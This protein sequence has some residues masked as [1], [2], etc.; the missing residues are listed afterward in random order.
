MIAADTVS[1][2][3][4]KYFGQW[5]VL[6]TPFRRISELHDTELDDLV[7]H[8]YYNL[9]CA[10]KR[11]PEYWRDPERIKKDMLLEA[12]GDEYITNILSMIQAKTQ[13]IED[14]ISG[15]IRKDMEPPEKPSILANRYSDLNV[16]LRVH[17]PWCGNPAEPQKQQGPADEELEW[18]QKQRQL[19]DN[20]DLRVDQA[21]L[22]HRGDPIEAEK[23]R[24]RAQE[25]GKA[26]A[27]LGGPGTGKTTVASASIHRAKTLGARILIA[28]PTGQMSSRMREIFPELEVDTCH[29]IF[30]FH[31][32]EMEAASLMSEYDLVVV[33]EVSQLSMEQFERIMRLWMMADRVPALIFLGDFYQLPGVDPTRAIDSMAWK[34][35]VYKI[36][37]VKPWRCKCKTLM[38]KIQATRTAKP[39]QKN[40]MSIKRGHEAWSG[41]LGPSPADIRRIL[42]TTNKKTTFVTC[43]RRAANKINKLVVNEL[44]HRP[45]V[46]LLGEVP[47]HYDIEPDNYDDHG[48]LKADIPP[49]PATISLYKGMRLFLTHNMDKKNDFVN[50]MEVMVDAFRETTARGRKGKSIRVL[51]KTGKY[52][53]V[54]LY[55]ESPIE[56]DKDK[57][58][59][60]YPIRIGYAT[61]L[62][63]VQ[64][65]TL[66]HATIWLDITGMKAAGHVALSRVQHDTDYLPTPQLSFLLRDRTIYI[67]IYSVALLPFFDMNATFGFRACVCKAYAPNNAFNAMWSSVGML[68]MGIKWRASCMDAIV[69]VSSNVELGNAP[70]RMLAHMTYQLKHVGSFR[71]VPSNCSRV[72][73]RVIIETSRSASLTCMYIHAER[74]RCDDNALLRINGDITPEHFVPAM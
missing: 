36:T 34:R 53:E 3:N 74:T 7:P 60:F 21:L 48:K 9:A 14:Y 10:L 67:Y 4:D 26:V 49:K 13:L 41:E 17:W 1:R 71:T 39:T 22:A 11:C 64:G 25:Y 46:E 61:T 31:R 2:M 20:I 52:L 69:N 68:G 30:L 55:T 24:D 42:Q 33:D 5:L 62:H 8:R 54:W 47:G 65:A 56:G 16:G 28:V 37:L 38:R 70:A 40:V 63:K 27:G 72:S 43:T 66:E 29:G 6:H 57:R 18:H 59:T 12:N 58:V 45:Q 50:G 51:T 23:A 19:K 44:F 15:R 32:P 73:T 35:D